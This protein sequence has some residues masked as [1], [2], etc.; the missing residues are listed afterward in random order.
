[1]NGFNRLNLPN[2]DLDG[3]IDVKTFVESYNGKFTSQ[4]QHNLEHTTDVVVIGQGNA[5]LDACRVLAR[6]YEQANS[7]PFS[8]KFMS[9]LQNS[10]IK[11]IQ[12]VGRRGIAQVQ[13]TTMEL[14]E[15]A[16]KINGIDSF[17]NRNEFDLGMNAINK[18]TLWKS[19][20]PNEARTR[21]KMYSILDQ[22]PDFN[23]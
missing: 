2:E 6:P 13:F 7:Y 5:G 21:E 3:I 1:M 22:L 10:N 20:N 19:F 16:T 23:Q 8:P 11:R 17:V 18:A 12:M 15:I 14:R 4:R 9:Q